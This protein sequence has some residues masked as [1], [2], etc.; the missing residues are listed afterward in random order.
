MLKNPL[1]KTN[2]ADF[3]EIINSVGNIAKKIN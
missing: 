1:K 3:Y 2:F